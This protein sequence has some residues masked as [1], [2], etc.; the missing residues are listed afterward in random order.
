[1]KNT[2]N[3]VSQSIATNH[4]LLCDNT[5]NI[6]NWLTTFLLLFSAE[7]KELCL[8]CDDMKIRRFHE[9]QLIEAL[10]FFE[11]FTEDIDLT[12]RMKYIEE[13]AVGFFLVMQLALSRALP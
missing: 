6:A 12:A 2:V 1:M 11:N 10:S 5:I 8:P 13:L 3:E 7:M 4:I 9:T